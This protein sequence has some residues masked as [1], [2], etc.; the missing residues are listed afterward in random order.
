VAAAARAR[1]RAVVAAAVRSRRRRTRPW[2][3]AAAATAGLRVVAAFGGLAKYE[4]VKELKAGG[5]PLEKNQLDKIEQEPA[6]KEEL[7]ALQAKLTDKQA[8]EGKWR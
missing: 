6:I 3:A 1:A 2:V 7:A 8:E 5:K 4:Q